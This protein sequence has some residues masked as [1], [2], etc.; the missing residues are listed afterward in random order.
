MTQLSWA[1]L[2]DSFHTTLSLRHSPHVVATAVLHLAMQCCKLV[3]PGA[4]EA[5]WAWW[6][7]FGKGSTESELQEIAEEIMEC[8]AA[9][10]NKALT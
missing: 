1:L 8:V 6:E 2:Q 7:V 4:D 10:T 9:R 5:R 3:I